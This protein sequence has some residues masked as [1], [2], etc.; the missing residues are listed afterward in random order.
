MAQ[1]IILKKLA[2]GHRNICVVGDDSQSIY[3]FRGAQIQNILNFQKDFPGA[4]VFRLERNYR[5][6]QTIVNAANSL[7]AHNEGRI[8][9]Q[10]VSM[11]EKGEVIHLVRS[12]TEQEEAQQI[13]YAILARMR[14]AQLPHQ[15]AVPRAGRAASPPQHP[16]H[17]LFRQFVF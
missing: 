14:E 15:L 17:D 10:C 7:I 5:S 9:K 3:G 8:P 16:L 4:K 12:F 2:A 6:T 13:A 1:Y 11:G